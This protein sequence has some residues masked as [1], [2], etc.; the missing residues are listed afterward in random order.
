MV[1]FPP[2][3]F[4]DVESESSLEGLAQLSD[5]HIEG[6]VAELLHHRPARHL[7]EVAA[8]GGGAL[9]VGDLARNRGELLSV[10]DPLPRR[11]DLPARRLAGARTVRGAKR[12]EY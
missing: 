4:K 12:G 5:G 9:I 8:L 6:N 2:F 3:D 10:H 1:R 7:A 11:E